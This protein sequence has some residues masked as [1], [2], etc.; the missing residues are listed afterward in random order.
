[1][2][3]PGSAGSTVRTPFRRWLWLYL[4]VKLS[5]FVARS[6]AA[7]GQRQTNANAQQGG[8]HRKVV[9]SGGTL[10][11]QPGGSLQPAPKDPF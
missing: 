4:E 10:T 9:L 2:G 6:H 11:P 8:F 3:S 7:A 1:M 5:A